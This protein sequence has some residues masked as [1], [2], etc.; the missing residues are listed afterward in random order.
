MP[1]GSFDDTM[2]L[3][4]DAI[5]L[6]SRS[7]LPWL[8]FKPLCLWL[9]VELALGLVLGFS[10]G[11]LGADFQATGPWNP[12]AVLTIGQGMAAILAVG[13]WIR[14][15]MHRHGPERA[16]LIG[17]QPASGTLLNTLGLVAVTYVILR[18]VQAPYFI[19]LTQY[20]GM[21]FPGN[22]PFI[23]GLW[24]PHAVWT[25]AVFL[26]IAPVMEEVVLRGYL[27]SG[28]QQRMSPILAVIVTAALFASA[29][30]S[31]A[32]W[33]PLFFL[34]LALGAVREKT[35]SVWPCIGL[36][37]LNNAVYLILEG[38]SLFSG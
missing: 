15:D 38:G 19:W 18:V 1:S 9:G 4:V 27:Q 12:T 37:G 28:L 2:A 30:L 3:S 31:V 17:W 7:S 5:N 32:N 16:S 23:E 14:N 25:C 34:G 24:L 29:H 21:P 20:S 36:H 11:F 10:L 33:L 6:D 35:G 8:G 22:A 13:I 26:V